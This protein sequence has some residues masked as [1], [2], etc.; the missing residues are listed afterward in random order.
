MK[1]SSNELVRRPDL[2]EEL[3]EI[4][5]M[6]QMDKVNISINI[7]FSNVKFYLFFIINF[8]FYD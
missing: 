7:I 6:L 4:L 8:H 1:H 3:Q 2:R 5:R